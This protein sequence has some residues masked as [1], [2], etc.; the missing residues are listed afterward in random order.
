MFSGNEQGF[1]FDFL[2]YISV[3]IK[4]TGNLVSVSLGQEL[5]VAPVFFLTFPFV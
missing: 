4:T 5:L 1:M 2:Y 3:Y